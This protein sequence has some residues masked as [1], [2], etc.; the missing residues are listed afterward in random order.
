LQRRPEKAKI[1]PY[2]QGI[3]GMS[4]KPIVETMDA[5]LLS[6]YGRACGRVLARAHAKTG[7]QA[8]IS[9][10][11]GTSDQFDEAMADFAVAYS[12]QAEKNYA[13]LKAAVRSGKIKVY[14]EQ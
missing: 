7:D 3:W 10:Y 14:Q 5:E 4:V 6:V 11:L 2:R 8:T 1:V 9:G 13:A 12:D